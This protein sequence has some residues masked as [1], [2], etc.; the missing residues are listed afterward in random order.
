VS[1]FL[2]DITPDPGNSSQ[3]LLNLDLS[4][5]KEVTGAQLKNYLDSFQVSGGWGLSSEP[6]VIALQF[7]VPNSAVGTNP[8][9]VVGRDFEY[10]SDVTAQ[11]TD[12]TPAP[13]P[14]AV[15]GGAALLA[16]MA[17]GHACAAKKS[18]ADRAF[19]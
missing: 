6:A 5:L 1:I 16:I 2:N 14:N 10:H 7:D 8:N 4:P 17:L 3:Y 19:P 15:A 18:R 11:A 9:D 12:A 13:L